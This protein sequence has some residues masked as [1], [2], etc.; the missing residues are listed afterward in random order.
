VRVVVDTNVLVSGVFFGGVPRQVLEAWA[1]GQF[2]LV[3][4]PSIF[5]EYLTTCARLGSKHP[6]L[7]YLEV[8]ATVAGHGTLIPDPQSADA[9][10]ADPDDDKFMI[11]AQ[12][13]DAV[14]VSGDSD[15]LEASGWEGVSVLTPRAFSE[16]LD[17]I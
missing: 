11:C 8:L 4:T 16:L 2:E 14:V 1:A 3:L 5:D 12:V 10:T 6:G 17:Q 15:L 7:E 9:I 13:A